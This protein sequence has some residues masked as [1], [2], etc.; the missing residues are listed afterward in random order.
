MLGCILQTIK[1]SVK[2]Y[3]KIL[4]SLRKNSKLT[5]R[6][7]SEILGLTTR[8][9]EKQIATLKKAQRLTRYGS[10]IKGYWEVING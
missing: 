5:I 3:E 2:S 4:I 6:E 10:A 8:A 9:V 1:S 7:L